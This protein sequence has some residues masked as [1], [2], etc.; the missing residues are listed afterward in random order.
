M[1]SCPSASRADSPLLRMHPYGTRYSAVTAR[2]PPGRRVRQ[3]CP[4]EHRVGR[5]TEAMARRHTGL[6]D[7]PKPLRAPPAGPLPAP[8]DPPRSLWGWD[9]PQRWTGS[10][11]HQAPEATTAGRTVDAAESARPERRPSHDRANASTGTRTA[12]WGPARS[13]GYDS[14]RGREM[15]AIRRFYTGGVAAGRR[16]PV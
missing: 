11:R 1:K 2:I 8:R 13:R 10:P 6:S 9:G 7:G 15:P 12:T 14:N 5:P 16:P 3:A 4:P